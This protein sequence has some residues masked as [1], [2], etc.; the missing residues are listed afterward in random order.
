MSIVASRVHM[1][2]AKL[3]MDRGANVNARD[4]AGL[5]ILERIFYTNLE[6]RSVKLLL[7]YGACTSQRLLFDALKYIHNVYSYDPRKSIE[8]LLDHGADANSRD[9]NNMTALEQAVRYQ[10][11]DAVQILLEYGADIN[12][13]TSNNKNIVRLTLDLE[14]LNNRRCAEVITH[15][16]VKMQYA[17][18]FVSQEILQEIANNNELSYAKYSCNFEMIRE[19]D[20]SIPFWKILTYN[21]QSLIYF[22]RNESTVKYLRSKECDK[23]FQIYA[24]HFRSQIRRALW[25]NIL[26]DKVKLFFRAVAKAKGNEHL[27]VLPRLCVDEIFSY[28]GNRDLRNLIRVCDPFNYFDL[29]IQNIE[30]EEKV[31]IKLSELRIS[32]YE[33]SPSSDSS[34]DSDHSIDF[35]D[36]DFMDCSDY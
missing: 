21:S 33:D 22:A 30:L 20:N 8:L 10:R 23:R 18:L 28:L 17:K 34:D 7:H 12:I 26:L 5:T 32:T 6:L 4:N 36:S 1:S 31:P 2:I 13:P 29:D 19:I 3:L 27:P 24:S 11:E 35:F 9:D 16:V 14:F 25:R 15:H